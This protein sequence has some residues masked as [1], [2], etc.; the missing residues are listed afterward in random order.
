M[1]SKNQ[2]HIRGQRSRAERRKGGFKTLVLFRPRAL[3]AHANLF[4]Y[5]FKTS[6][7]FGTRIGKNFPN[8]GSVFARLF[9]IRLVY[10]IDIR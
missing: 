4:Q 9:T 3:G 10:R 6:Q 2:F 5:C 1:I 8:F 7:F